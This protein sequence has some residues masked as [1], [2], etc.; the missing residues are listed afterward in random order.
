MARMHRRAAGAPALYERVAREMEGLM[1][2][3]TLRPGDRM[4]SLRALARERGVSLSTALEAYRVLEDRGRL[5]VRDRSGHYVRA[6]LPAPPPSRRRPALPPAP[7]RVRVD[8]LAVEVLRSCRDPRLLRLAAALP[9]PALLPTAALNRGLSRMGR[10]APQGGNFYDDPQGSA[11]LRVQVARRALESGCLLRPGDLVTTQGTQDGVGLLLTAL[12]REGD[13][14]AVE[15][16]AFFGL[17]QILERLRLRA[18]PVHCDA[19]SGMDPGSLD[20]AL[21]THPAAAVVLTSHFQNPL[22][23]SVPPARLR[24]IVAAAARRSVPLVEVDVLGDLAHSGER[25]PAARSFDRTGNVLLVSSVSKTLGPGLR[26]GWTAPGR[27]L[28]EVM[29]VKVARCLSSPV[30]GPMAVA[31]F[32]A[33]GGCDRTL[34]RARRA[35]ALSTAR[36]ADAV[37][38]SFPRG[39]RVTRPEGG[40]LLWV[41]M[42]RAVDALRL[43]RVALA[44]GIAFA[45]G[46]LFS[47][48]GRGFRNCLRLNAA[49]ASPEVIAGVERLGALAGAEGGEGAPPP[50]LRRAGKGPL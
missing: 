7:L 23:G 31:D 47:P 24:E 28:P 15:S 48:R 16:P 6:R 46:P 14:V 45:P 22:G 41:E 32:L 42:P 9:D 12:C 4:P 1:E 39:T 21:R 44:A 5:E 50:F 19:R 43:H 33:H 37:A 2:A 13:A 17:L 30:L 29:R 20:H 34:R 36:V 8:D 26:V 40:F 27:L 3:G 25:P 18:L 38:R 35:Y 11:A 49:V 10:R